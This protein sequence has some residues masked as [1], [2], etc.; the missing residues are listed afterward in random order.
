MFREFIGKPQTNNLDTFRYLVCLINLFPSICTT[1]QNFPL[2]KKADNRTLAHELEK[3]VENFRN[4]QLK[5]LP[6]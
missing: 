5:A 3:L 2:V 4:A 6:R 1:F